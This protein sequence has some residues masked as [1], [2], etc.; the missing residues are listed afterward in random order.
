MS[1]ETGTQRWH[2]KIAKSKPEKNFRRHE[3]AMV[4]SLSIGIHYGIT[5]DITK[6]SPSALESYL[7]DYTSNKA[8]SRK[9][10]HNFI[11]M[12]IG[13]EVLLG[14]GKRDILYTATISSEAYFTNNPKFI[15]PERD[16]PTGK[17]YFIRRNI[18]NLMKHTP[19][20][21]LEGGGHI[22][23]LTREP[24]PDQW[25]FLSLSNL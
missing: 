3:E 6:L 4:A 10:I 7:I 1:N 5:E 9:M 12:K 21:K 19:V 20:I 17:G 11:H 15:E 18:T 16:F 13:D 22:Q 14:R 25:K 24:T 23:T 8:P 2:T